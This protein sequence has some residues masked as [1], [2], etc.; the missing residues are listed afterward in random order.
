MIALSR[1]ETGAETEGRAWSWSRG[2]GQGLHPIPIP[3]EDS[4]E[5][6]ME[7]GG[8]WGGRGA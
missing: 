1:Q 4:G 6:I 7:M 8:C 2:K 5:G 3:A